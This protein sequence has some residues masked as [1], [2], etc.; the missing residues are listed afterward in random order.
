MTAAEKKFN[1]LIETNTL[2]KH[3]N[4][5]GKQ[6]DFFDASYSKQFLLNKVRKHKFDLYLEENGLTVCAPEV[7]SLLIRAMNELI[8]E[9]SV[10]FDN[11]RLYIRYCNHRHKHTP[12]Q[13]YAGVALELWDQGEL[14]PFFYFMLS[15]Y[16]G[17]FNT[18]EVGLSVKCTNIK[19][20]ILMR[21]YR[22]AFEKIKSVIPI[23]N[24]S[25][26]NLY[27]YALLS[28]MYNISL[29]KNCENYETEYEELVSYT[30]KINVLYPKLN[31]TFDETAR[32]NWNKNY[33]LSTIVQET[34]GIL[35][36][37]DLSSFLYESV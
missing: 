24:L 28:K 29:S 9:C 34:K 15:P 21:N 17:E 31:L 12:T 5:L 35:K 26:A 10:K 19:G 36:F 14:D 7:Y 8:N 25:P 32:F 22:K 33:K 2:I 16:I 11:S 13:A 6:H 1:L 23:T 30:N 18:L 3:I 37:P 4:E 20:I 27:L